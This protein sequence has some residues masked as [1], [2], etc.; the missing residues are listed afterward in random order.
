MSFLFLVIAVGTAYLISH[1]ILSLK[2][3]ATNDA[4]HKQQ[5]PITLDFLIPGGTYVDEN[6][7]IREVVKARLQK[8]RR[9]LDDFLLKLS[10]I[11][12]TKYLLLGTL[13]LYLFWTFLFLVFFRIFTWIGYGLAL[14][15]S[16]LAGSIVYF[17]MPDL[18]FGKIDDVVLL[19]WAV[20]FAVACRWYSKR[21]KLRQSYS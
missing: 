9:R 8:P 12:P 10:E 7:T 21:R 11:I 6:M 17:F 4:L 15:I 5:A 3:R 16:F 2:F 20:A 19:G 18:M 14:S 1:K 13:L